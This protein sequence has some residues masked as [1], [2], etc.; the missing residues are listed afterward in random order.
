MIKTIHWFINTSESQN[1]NNLV[2]T[3]NTWFQQKR[4]GSSKQ[5]TVKH[6]PTSRKDTTFLNY[7]TFKPAYAF[8]GD[9]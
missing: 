7:D 4:H 9:H 1:K 3:K 5:K 8:L 2:P 6:Y